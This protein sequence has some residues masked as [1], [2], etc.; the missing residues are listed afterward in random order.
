MTEAYAASIAHGAL[1]RLN[2]VEKILPGQDQL[3]VT[4]NPDGEHVIHAVT[5]SVSGARTAFVFTAKDGTITSHGKIILDEGV[6]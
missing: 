6:A 1:T 2:G 4:I 3:I 5:A